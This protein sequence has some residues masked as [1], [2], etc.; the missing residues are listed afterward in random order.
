MPKAAL[1]NGVGY[2]TQ[3]ISSAPRALAPGYVDMW[4]E[5]EALTPPDMGLR[6]PRVR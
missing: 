5:P 1:Q 6:K 4:G 3:G 2:R